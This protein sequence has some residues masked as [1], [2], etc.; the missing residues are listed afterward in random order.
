[1]QYEGVVITFGTVSDSARL[2]LNGGLEPEGKEHG[3]RTG[4]RRSALR[5]LLDNTRWTMPTGRAY[6]RGLG[7]GG[8]GRRVKV[9]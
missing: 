5:R 3:E 9:T 1:M 7:G 6:R 8:S 4:L 2:E